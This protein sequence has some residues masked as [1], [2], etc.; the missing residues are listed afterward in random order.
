MNFFRQLSLILL[1][2]ATPA[3]SAVTVSSP[4]NDSTVTSP[5]HFA[6]TATA[7]TCSKGVGS[8]GILVNNEEVY[9]I[10]STALDTEVALPAGVQHIVVTAWDKCGGAAHAKLTLTVTAP[11]A[12]VSITAS[13]TSVAAGKSSTLTVVAANATKVTVTGSN[14]SSYT[15]GATGGTKA[16][17]PSATTTYTATATGTGGKVLS[18]VTVTVLPAPTINVAA[19]PTT[20]PAGSSSSLT[21]SA[22]N[23][24]K[25][26]IAGSDGS[27]YTL[28]ANGGTVPVT[29]AATTTYTATAIGVGGQRS[30]S[31]TVKVNAPPA[32]RVSIAANPASIAAGGSATLIVSAAGATQVI[33]TGGDGSSYALSSTGGNVGVNP[34]ATTT[35]T[36]KASGAGGSTSAATAVT[37]VPAPTVSIAANPTSVKAGSS[38]T[39]TVT[40]TN[41]TQ[42]VISGS[43]GSSYTLGG[44]G[45][46]QSVTP[47]ANTTYLVTATGIGG[48]SSASTSV[49]VIPA[50]TVSIVANPSAIAAGGSSRLTVSA[51]NDTQ[52][53]VSG[54]DGST[55]GV[56]ATGGVVTVSPTAA[57]TTYTATATGAG[58]TASSAATITISGAPTVGIS[59]NPTNIVAGTSSNLTVTTTNA[60]QVTITGSDGSSYNVPVSGGSQLVSPTVTTTYTVNVTGV[61]G[62]NSSQIT[63]N[64]T[65]SP[66]IL[67][68][69]QTGPGWES[70]GQLPPDYQDCSPCSG[71]SWLMTEGITNPSYSLSG[72]STEFDT[73]GTKP[74]AVVLWV[75]PVIGAYSTQGLPDKSQTLIPTLNNFTYDADVYVTN[76]GITQALELDVAM[77][78]GGNALFWG[79]QCAPLGDHDWDYLN[80]V[81]KKWVSTGFECGLVNGW[82]HVTW[83]FRRLPGN[84]LQYS[85]I[86]L[87]GVASYVNETSAEYTVPT[88][89]YGITV[90]YQMDG[91]KTQASN[92]TYVDNLTL[93]YW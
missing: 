77:Y 90:N 14:G 78:F 9:L 35:Y 70:Y 82:N 81:T 1:A 51:T 33:V 40:A 92:T 74:Y 6:V 25:V 49:S 63:V 59:A 7:P 24:T 10:H 56:V 88:S 91:N 72:N 43:D 60:N 65:T 75:D 48:K 85:S 50:P 8:I 15:L 21:A 13:P 29:P 62:T 2:L 57:T 39:L 61:A 36:A 45:G 87:N 52:L 89:W 20:I 64:V 84:E 19:S 37:V 34:A 22:S 42:V 44:T 17:S 86:T 28:G 11:E 4:A 73:S 26:T 76:V 46:T 58:G 80:N 66:G 68:N 3:Y 41:S 83:Q 31:A 54:S 93:T 47:G 38:S 69:L 23:A 16:V 18:A 55:Y 5:A 53:T 32:P 30:M 27:A 12:T 67:G 79:T 71:I